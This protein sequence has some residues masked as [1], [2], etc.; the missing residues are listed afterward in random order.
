MSGPRPQGN[1]RTVTEAG[2]L[3]FTA[4][5]TPRVQGRLRF[6]GV[7][8]ADLDLETARAAADLCARGAVAALDG[9]GVERVVK[10]TVHLV[11]A[12]GFTD[13]ARV[14]DAASD[15]VVELLGQDA[16]GVRTTV[17]VASLPGGAPVEIDLVAVGGRPA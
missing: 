15:A 16:V 17:G 14:A 7:I 1:Y 4:G 10:M 2:G 12:P 5:I 8:G 11:C 6:T 9:H 3:V 13:H